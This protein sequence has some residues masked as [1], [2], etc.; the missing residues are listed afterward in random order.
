MSAFIKLVFAAMLLVGL[1]ATQISSAQEGDAQPAVSTH[2]KSKTT[3]K[4]VS[5]TLTGKVHTHSVKSGKMNKTTPSSESAMHSD[6]SA[7]MHK[8]TKKAGAV[9]TKKVGKTSSHKAH[10]TRKTPAPTE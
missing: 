8:A 2:Q 6:K 5:K 9:K 7:R 1:S 4:K 3:H 10:H